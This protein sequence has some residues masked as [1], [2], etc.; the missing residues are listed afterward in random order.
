MRD[1]GRLMM[2]GSHGA[3]ILGSRSHGYVIFHG[4]FKRCNDVLFNL[5]RPFC[6]T[7]SDRQY[8]AL[9]NLLGSF[10]L[11]PTEKIDSL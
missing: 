11:S 8:S 5:K 10:V 7:F 3:G 1:D 9:I 6:N 4:P 2:T